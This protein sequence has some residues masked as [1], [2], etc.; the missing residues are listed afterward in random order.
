MI[1]LPP[2]PST[3]HASVVKSRAAKV[4]NDLIE[5][6]AKILYQEITNELTKPTVSFP[7][8]I[9]IDDS[10]HD[11][12]ET[13]EGLLIEAGYQTSVVENDDENTAFDDLEEAE[14]DGEWN[15]LVIN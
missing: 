5:K 15:W 7:L 12:V 13:V 1:S 2:F 11:S 8:W 10:N 6:D 14:P 3:L 9:G 4:K